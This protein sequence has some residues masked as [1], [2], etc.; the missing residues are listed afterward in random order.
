MMFPTRLCERTK[1]GPIAGGPDL[2]TFDGIIRYI[3]GFLTSLPGVAAVILAASHQELALELDGFAWA[4]GSASALL[5]ASAML[6]WSDPPILRAL[7][8]LAGFAG[9][10]FADF[11]AASWRSMTVATPGTSWR[12]FLLF[13]AL[14]GVLASLVLPVLRFPSNVLAEFALS[15]CGGACSSMLYFVM[16]RPDRDKPASQLGQL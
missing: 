16:R 2:R 3:A 7:G 14:S 5:F 1:T 9:P 13:G 8:A 4:I 11:V 12:F 15:A 10:A 6:P